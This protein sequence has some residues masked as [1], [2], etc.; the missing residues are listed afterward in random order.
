MIRTAMAYSLVQQAAPLFGKAVFSYWPTQ[1]SR[2]AAMS[3]GSRNVLGY[4]G[5]SDY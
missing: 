4:M 5:G 2:P 3:V 1:T